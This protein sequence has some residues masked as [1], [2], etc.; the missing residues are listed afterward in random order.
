MHTRLRFAANADLPAIFVRNDDGTESLLNFSMD[1]GDVIV[2]RVA[3]QFI[4]RRGK[5]AGCIVNQGFVGGGFAARVRHRDARCRAQRAGSRAMN[6]ANR[7]RPEEVAG[8]RGAT[9]VNRRR[10]RAIAVEQSYWPYRS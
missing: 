6:A 10:F 9:L 8:E 7:R 1:E 4:L 3:H 5:L 2:H